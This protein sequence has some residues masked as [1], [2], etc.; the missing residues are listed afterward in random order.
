M[1]ALR[2]LLLAATLGLSGFA[3]FVRAEEQPVKQASAVTSEPVENGQETGHRLKRLQPS[4]NPHPVARSITNVWHSQILLPCY[5]HF[6]D[7]SCGGIYSEV[8]FHFGSC[9]TFFGERCIKGPPPS[10]VPGFDPSV[11][12]P[13]RDCPFCR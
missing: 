12:Q 10:P 11:I 5:S 6:N 4:T 8:A 3:G 9:R 7:Y 1:R 13:K 2:Q